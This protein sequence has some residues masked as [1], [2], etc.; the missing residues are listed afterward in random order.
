[1]GVC[2]RSGC[3]RRCTGTMHN[4]PTPRRTSTLHRNDLS[5]VQSIVGLISRAAP[6]SRAHVPCT[7]NCTGTCTGKSFRLRATVGSGV[8]F[9]PEDPTAFQF[10]R[11]LSTGVK[12]EVKRH[13]DFEENHLFAYCERRSGS[14]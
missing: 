3:G 14:A 9:W 11:E 8:S 10:L 5:Q 6:C 12:A 4:A 1:M 2:E 13:F 7:G